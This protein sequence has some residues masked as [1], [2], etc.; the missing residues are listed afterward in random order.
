MS[1][2]A[3]PALLTI[4]QAAAALNVSIKTVRRLIAGGHL[5]AYRVGFGPRAQFRIDP[6]DLAAM[7]ERAS[8]R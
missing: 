8:S 5:S 2:A 3:E 4:R 7:I 1:T 6:E